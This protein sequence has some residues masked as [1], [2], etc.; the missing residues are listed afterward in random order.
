MI[1]KYLNSGVAEQITPSDIE[2][3]RKELFA[4]PLNGKNIEE[5]WDRAVATEQMHYMQVGIRAVQYNL[6]HVRGGCPDTDR[7][8]SNLAN[9]SRLRHRFSELFV[10]MWTFY[11]YSRLVRLG[12]KGSWLFVKSTDV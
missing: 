12:F 5:L 1:R 11:N 4:L 7:V 10:N 9:Q 3:Y 8:W 6:G 2:A